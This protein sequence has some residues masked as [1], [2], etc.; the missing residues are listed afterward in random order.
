MKGTNI[1]KMKL[2]KGHS[3]VNLTKVIKYL[4]TPL[5]WIRPDKY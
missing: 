3:K 1:R 4:F 5:R 2:R